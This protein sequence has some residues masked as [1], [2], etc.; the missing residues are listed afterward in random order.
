MSDK[1]FRDAILKVLEEHTDTSGEHQDSS[2]GHGCPPAGALWVCASVRSLLFLISW[3]KSGKELEEG[4]V[5]NW[6]NSV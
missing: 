6:F 5:M 4:L 3:R 2:Q 1:A